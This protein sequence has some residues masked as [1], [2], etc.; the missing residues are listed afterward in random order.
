MSGFVVIANDESS[1]VVMPNIDPFHQPPLLTYE[2]E[3]GVWPL[4]SALAPPLALRN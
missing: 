2:V 4:L 3:L 1:V